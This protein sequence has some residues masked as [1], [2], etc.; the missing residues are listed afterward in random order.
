MRPQLSA[1]CA[2]ALELSLLNR[3]HMV[4]MVVSQYDL[5]PPPVNDFGPGEAG[6]MALPRRW[7]CAVYLD[8]LVS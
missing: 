5:N 3:N 8:L 4:H 1:T 7:I 6:L 2:G